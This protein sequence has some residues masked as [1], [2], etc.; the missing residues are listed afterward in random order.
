VELKRGHNW[1][2]FYVENILEELYKGDIDDERA[3]E[4]IKNQFEKLK[5]EN[6]SKTII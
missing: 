6:F 3:L 1:F 4:L 2:G 5:K